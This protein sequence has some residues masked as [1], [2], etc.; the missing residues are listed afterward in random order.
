MKTAINVQKKSEV[1]PRQKLG[2]IL[3]MISSLIVT[4]VDSKDSIVPLSHSRATT[5]AVKRVPIRVMII[6]MEPGTRK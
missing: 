2:T 1:I 6:A 4:G 3:L 5:T